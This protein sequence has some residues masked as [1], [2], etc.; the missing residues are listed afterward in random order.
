MLLADL[1]FVGKG[2]HLK[3]TKVHGRGRSGKMNKYRAH[4]T[5]SP[6]SLLWLLLLLLLPAACM[7]HSKHVCMIAGGP[8]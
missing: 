8:A 6:A 7:P 2:Q 1:A 4:L 3:R 5:V